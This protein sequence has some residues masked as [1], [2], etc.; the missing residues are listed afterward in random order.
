[1]TFS[2]RHSIIRTMSYKVEQKVGNHVYVYE[3]ESYW[4]KEKKQPRQR[5]RYLG[6]KDPVSGKI[7]ATNAGYRSLDYGNTYFLGEICK[8]A[9][10]TAMLRE[11]FPA[12]WK[13]LIAC[14]FF[15]I[16]EK[17]ALYLCKPWLESTYL[18]VDT[19]MCSQRI[20]E[21]LRHLGE[22]EQMRTGFLEHWARSHKSNRFIVFDITSFS[23]YARK[24]ELLE[25]GYNR[26]GEKLPQVNFGVIYGEPA[27]LP[28]FYTRY[29]GSIPD[30]KTL[31]N[32]VEYLKW[33][34]I[35]HS[36]FVL[37]RGFFS[38]RNLSKMSADMQFLIP[39]PYST[40]SA[41]ALIR[42]YENKIRLDFRVTSNVNTVSAL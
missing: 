26:D 8:Q 40:N 32:M 12:I 16:S 14:I 25:W 35:S 18:D 13:E 34:K 17:K 9:G 11:H 23:S 24:L 36:L 41:L 6:K 5:R 37:D 19:D 39:L 27:S 15:E 20:S 28:L 2:W 1:M 21:M 22:E 3:A 29:P 38:S 7:V 10:L 31:N 30:V 42:N 33:L 4:D